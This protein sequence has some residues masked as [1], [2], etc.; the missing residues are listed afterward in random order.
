MDGIFP[1]NGFSAMYTYL[2]LKPRMRLKTQLAIKADIESLPPRAWSRK[3]LQNYLAE[4]REA[5]NAPQYLS[6]GLF[7]DFLI[8]N[9]L[10]RTSEIRSKEYGSKSRYVTGEL[11][12]LPFACSFFPRSYVSH[13]TALHVHGFLPIGTIYVNHEQSPKKTTSRLSQGAH[14]SSIPESTPP[15]GL[16]IQDGTPHCHFLERQEHP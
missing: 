1:K 13:A 15:F 7:I 6:T 8:E 2:A 14:R 16:R 3:D 12:I 10:A 5:W 9:E 4:K 11:T